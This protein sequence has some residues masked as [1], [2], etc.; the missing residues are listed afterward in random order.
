MNSP[1][2]L[3]PLKVNQLLKNFRLVNL[4]ADVVA[5]NELHQPELGLAH[6][7]QQIKRIFNLMQCLYGVLAGRIVKIAAS[8][9]SSKHILIFS[10]QIENGPVVWH[11]Q[12]RGIGM[13]LD[14]LIIVKLVAQ[15]VTL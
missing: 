4:C 9:L 6:I 8:K 15:Y 1:A 3:S 7:W 2:I 10:P 5:T 12:H 13:C 11:R 14:P